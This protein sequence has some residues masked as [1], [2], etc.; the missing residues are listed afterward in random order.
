MVNSMSFNRPTLSDLI[1]RVQ[2]D[3]QSRLG[4]SGKIVRNTMVW[5]F[6]RVYAGLAHGLY[7]FLDYISR[8]VFP[9][10]AEDENLI[11]WATLY[12]LTRIPATFAEGEVTV[13][14]TNDISIPSGTILERADGVEFQ[15]LSDVAIAGGTAILQV[16]AVVPEE[17]GNTELG[18]SLS[19]Q[20]PID[21]VDVSGLVTGEITGGG[22]L[23]SIEDLRTRLL[24]RM[25]AP[26][27]GGS[28]SDYEQWAKEVAGVTRA[29]V[30]PL[31]LGDGTVAIFFVRDNDDDIFPSVSEVEDVSGYIDERRPVTAHHYVYAPTGVDV[32]FTIEIS[33]DSQSVK[34]AVTGELEDLFFTDGEPGG[35]ILL[36]RMNEAI[37]L[38]IGETDHVLISP[39][40][41]Y[42]AAAGYLPQ[43]GTVTFT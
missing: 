4:L 25:R 36:S 13:T 41:D 22:D 20:V 38:A 5:I 31:Y 21:G 2:E 11:R 14:G 19:F 3:F 12:G 26:I 8:Q 35:T 40:A 15:V 24:A 27:Q 23:E 33:P 34:E 28:A 6:A 37:S 9:D 43:L 10:T 30:K 29:W 32:N 7:G 39:S 17:N 42:G 18:V 1:V 16:R